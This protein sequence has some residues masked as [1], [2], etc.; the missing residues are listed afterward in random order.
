MRTTWETGLQ[1]THDQPQHNPMG[2][3]LSF[4]LLSAKLWWS[5]CIHYRVPQCRSFIQSFLASS[6]GMVILWIPVCW[7][8]CVCVCVCVWCVSVESVSQV[9]SLR[10]LHLLTTWHEVYSSKWLAVE[11]SKHTYTQIRHTYKPLR[12]LSVFVDLLPRHQNVK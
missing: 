8:V 5:T 9:L 3:W 4:C 2:E 7:C 11:M 6:M 10:G 12:R 1:Y